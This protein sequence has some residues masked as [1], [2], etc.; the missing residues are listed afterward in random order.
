MRHERSQGDKGG[1]GDIVFPLHARLDV[2]ANSGKGID[3]AVLLLCHNGVVG[4]ESGALRAA[5]VC[6]LA[7]RLRLAAL[8]LLMGL[9][10]S[11]NNVFL[12][13]FQDRGATRT[14]PLR[15]VAGGVPKHIQRRQTVIG[16]QISR[17]YDPERE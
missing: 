6:E 12:V 9:N 17:A 13:H 16:F 10:R 1:W 3:D 4:V 8:V 5:Q 14:E 7:H 15:P 11:L 2:Q